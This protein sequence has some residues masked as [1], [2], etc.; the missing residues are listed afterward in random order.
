VQGRVRAA[1]SLWPLLRPSG[2]LV[3]VGRG[4][5]S[6]GRGSGRDGRGGLPPPEGRHQQPAELGQV[7]F[8]FGL[9]VAPVGADGSWWPADEPFYPPYSWCEQRAVERVPHVQAVVDDN[10]VFVVHHLAT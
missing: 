5:R 4:W 1:P 3:A 8:H 7:P 10:A 2:H 9:A 6:G